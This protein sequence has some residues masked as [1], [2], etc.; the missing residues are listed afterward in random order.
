VGARAAG[1]VVLVAAWAIAGCGGTSERD[2]VRSYIDSANRVEAGAGPALQRANGVYGQFS[3]G[4][5]PQSTAIADLAQAE[6]VIRGLRTRLSRLHP[7]PAARALH[8]QLL[9][10]LDLNVEMAR[11]ST[12]LAIY[13]PDARA[14]LAAVGPIN[15]S[16]R[17]RLAASSTPTGQGAA[18]GRYRRSLARV[19]GRLQR[20]SPPP[21]LAATHAAQIVR[22]QTAGDLARRLTTAV[23]ARDAPLVARLLLRF[24]RVNASG[25]GDKALTSEEI[26][27]YDTRYGLIGEATAQLRR[28]EARLQRTLG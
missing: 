2:R 4:K 28:E 9:R 20:L 19:V 26:R 15:T 1:A 10:V 11:E 18:L 8:R 22:L 3:K 27:S 24:R 23:Q 5:L 17:V 25:A 21:I 14:A 6:D 13:L 12:E 16:L 7:P